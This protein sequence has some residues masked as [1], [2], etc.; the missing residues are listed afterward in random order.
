VTDLLAPFKPLTDIAQGIASIGW[1]LMKQSAAQNEMFRVRAVCFYNAGQLKTCLVSAQ[2][3][4]ARGIGKPPRLDV[5]TVLRAVDA[6]I[7]KASS[8]ETDRR[9]KAFFK[10]ANFTAEAWQ[11]RNTG[12]RNLDK[13]MSQ[14]IDSLGTL[15]GNMAKEHDPMKKSKMQKKLGIMQEKLKGKASDKIAFDM[16]INQAHAVARIESASS[17]SS[18]AVSKEAWED[19]KQHIQNEL[20]SKLNELHQT[21]EMIESEPDVD[22][23]QSMMMQ[24]RQQQLGIATQLSNVENAGSG[25]GITVFVIP[26]YKGCRGSSTLSI[27]SWMHSL[28]MSNKL[29]VI[30]EC[31]WDAP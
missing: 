16:S 31:W 2:A 30:C 3:A 27:A 7:V 13:E 26:F 19:Q 5:Q 1:Y 8:L 21:Q 10:T 17:A 4:R 14:D 25:L 24:V 20:Q 28:L 18:N 22:L 6:L 23:K 15:I 12:W 9:M 29:P 11:H